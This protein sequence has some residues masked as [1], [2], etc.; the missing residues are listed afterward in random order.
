MEVVQPTAVWTLDEEKSMLYDILFGGVPTED[1]EES[2]ESGCLCGCEL[3]RCNICDRVDCETMMD[4][5][6]PCPGVYSYGTGGC[7]LVGE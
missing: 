6:Y 4:G 1:N 3:I 2:C 7:V 5:G